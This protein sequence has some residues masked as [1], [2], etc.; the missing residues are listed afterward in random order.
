M[1]TYKDNGAAL[2]VYAPENKTFPLFHINYGNAESQGNIQIKKMALAVI[3]K[4]KAKK[5]N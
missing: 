4:L 3:R 2:F 5:V 1:Y